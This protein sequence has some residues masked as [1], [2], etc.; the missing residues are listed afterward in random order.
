MATSD[1]DIELIM[2][3]SSI[4]GSAGREEISLNGSSTAANAPESAEQNSLPPAD[5]GK[6]AWLVLA[7][8]SLIQAPVWGTQDY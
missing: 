8:C 5:R 6:A 3:T 4:S 1:A 2:P 7:G